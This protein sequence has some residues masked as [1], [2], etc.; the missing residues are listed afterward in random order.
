MLTNLRQNFWPYYIHSWW[1]CALDVSGILWVFRIFAALHDLLS[2]DLSS[3][4]ADHT[5][6]TCI[7]CNPE[8]FSEGE[9]SVSS[10]PFHTTNMSSLQT[11]V[12]RIKYE[13]SIIEEY[14]FC[15]SLGRKRRHSEWKNL[16]SNDSWFDSCATHLIWK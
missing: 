1:I 15:L 13:S 7:V 14:L 6:N 12:T 16:N 11:F 3:G 2:D 5:P 9:V 4:L 10:N 8:C